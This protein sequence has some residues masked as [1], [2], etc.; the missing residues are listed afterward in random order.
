MRYTAKKNRNDA[1]DDGDRLV[2][3]LR[4]LLPP[5]PATR[6]RACSVR[7]RLPSGLRPCASSWAE[8]PASRALRPLAV[9]CAARRPRHLVPL[10]TERE[11]AHCATTGAHADAQ[12]LRSRSSWRP[13]SVRRAV[14]QIRRRPA[15]PRADRD[16]SGR[17]GG[18]AV[19]T[20]ILFTYLFGLVLHLFIAGAFP[21]GG[22]ALHRLSLLPALAVALPRIAMTV[23]LLRTSI[24]DEAQRLRPHLHEPRTLAQRYSLRHVLKKHAR[25]WP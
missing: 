24:L 12:R 9:G 22:G 15:R 13:H 19:F 20:G 3:D 6:R 16:Q 7:R 4:C 5:S 8:R 11:L 25:A 2:F 1:A 21:A 23:K 18:A 17:D 10:R 14:G